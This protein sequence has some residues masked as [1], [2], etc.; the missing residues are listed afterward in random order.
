MAQDRHSEEYKKNDFCARCPCDENDYQ[1]VCKPDWGEADTWKFAQRVRGGGAGK[2]N[3][4]A[5]HILCWSPIVGVFLDAKVL[6][7]VKSTKWCVNK[8]SNMIA[9][10]LW[11]HTV[12]WYTNNDDEPKFKNL[13][14]HDIDHNKNGGYTDEVEDS[15]KKFAQQIQKAMSTHQMPPDENLAGRLD[16]ISKGYEGKLKSRGLRG[17]GTH[18]SWKDGETMAT[19]YLAF[20]MALTGQARVRS[21]TQKRDSK[22]AAIAAAQKLLSGG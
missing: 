22:K 2:R 3:Y 9:L 21:F 11:G 8:K 17:G 18:K 16:Q 13:P 6:P 14:N 5:H 7:I 1:K 20:S 12:Q 19:W 4:E 15:L 10:P